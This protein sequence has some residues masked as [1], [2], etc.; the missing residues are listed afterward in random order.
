MIPFEILPF[1]DFAMRPEAQDARARARATGATRLQE[2]KTQRKTFGHSLSDTRAEACLD[3]RTPL[4]CRTLL[5]PRTR[6]LSRARN[7]SSESELRAADIE[8]D[9]VRVGAALSERVFCLLLV[10]I[11]RAH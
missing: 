5:L 9:F 2:D 8:E 4:R 10:Q 3:P 7:L 1:S 11:G 6:L